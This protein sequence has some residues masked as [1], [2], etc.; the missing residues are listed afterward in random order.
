VA[1]TYQRTAPAVSRTTGVAAL[2]AL[3]IGCFM[4]TFDV[5]VVTVAV[6]RI[7]DDLHADLTSLQ[8]VVDGYTLVFAALM[9]SAGD[10]GDRF[11]AR[12][13]FLGGLAVFG[14]GSLLCGLAP[15]GGALI[16]FRLLQGVG[17][18]AMIP[19]SLSLLRGMYDDRAARARAFGVW[20]MVAGVAAAT[21]PVLGGLFVGLIG[22][23]SV[24]FLNMPFVLCAYLMTRRYVPAIDTG[25][26]RGLGI[27]SQ[28]IGTVAVAALVFG[29]NEAGSLGWTNAVVLA[30]F[31]VTVLTCVVFPLTLRSPAGGSRI[32]VSGGA[33]FG[34]AAAVGLLFNFGFFGILFLAPIYFQRV[35]HLSPLVTGCALLPI[36]VPPILL[37]AFAGRTVGRIGPRLPAVIGLSAGTVGLVGWL[38]AGPNTAYAL[39]LAPL[40]LGGIA[41]AFTLPSA[42]AA[43]M[44][45]VPVDQ[46]GMGSAVFNTARQVGGAIGVALVGSL[47]SGTNM[48]R[49]LHLGVVGAA[50]ITLVAAAIA[51]RFFGGAPATSSSSSR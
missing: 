30:C 4:V 37:S 42:T 43:I 25:A 2:V 15:T 21:G 3:C 13:V 20:S 23:R 18:A 27:T 6:P 50:I 9:L 46:G 41:P 17:A 38:I 14:V 10:L 11:S 19:S 45:S 51:A 35:A 8:W 29:L 22:W 28:V 34:A 12:G 31:A 32:S 48:V 40:L 39:L 44:E 24:F 26:N 7:G 49:G 47:T 1:E 36:A 33:E 16:G 5:S